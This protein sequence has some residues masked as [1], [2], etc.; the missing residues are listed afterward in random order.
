METIKNGSID[1][2]T[3]LG[4]GPAGLAVGYYAGQRGIP[5]MVY[6]AKNRIGGNCTTYRHKGFHFDS[7]AHRLHGHN[8]EVTQEFKQLLGE[9]LMLINLPS[10]IHYDGKNINFPLTPLNLM[11]SLGFGKFCKAAAEIL[12]SRLTAKI[13]ENMNFESFALRTYGKT[14][15]NRFL[16]NYTEKLWGVPCNQ[17]STSIAGKRLKGLNLRMLLLEM[18]STRRS[19]SKHLDGMFYYPQMGIGTA[20]NRLAASFS[21]QNVILN[22]KITKV[23]HNNKA[24]QALEINHKDIIDVDKV[25]ST[26]PIDCLIRMMEPLAPREIR[27]LVDKLRYRNIRLAAFF[28]NRNFITQTATTYF[29]DRRMPFTRIYEPKNRC[30]NMAPHGKTSLVA[31][32]PCDYGDIDDTMDNDIL[33]KSVQKKLVQLKWIKPHDIIDVATHRLE[34]AYPILS[35]EAETIVRRAL[36]YLESFNNL[37]LSGRNAEFSYVWLHNVM[38]SGMEIVKK[39]YGHLNPISSK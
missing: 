20:I 25:V 27:A 3:I 14:I 32:I 17:L 35:I 1:K 18:I 39:W 6:E 19:V 13:P 10:Q 30:M 23:F 12:S 4:A 29:S 36:H 21:K 34:H 22:S 11:C 2:I 33:I 5:F 8:P 28:L 31:E 16:L 38:K 37:E 24:I 9:E 26:L 7:G 15:A